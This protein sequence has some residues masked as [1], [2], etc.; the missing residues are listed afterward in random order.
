MQCTAE[1]A[2][3]GPTSIKSHI[4]TTKKPLGFLV[5]VALDQTWQSADKSRGESTQ[6]QNYFNGIEFRRNEFSRAGVFHRFISK[7]HTSIE[8]P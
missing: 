8:T 4:K 5:E 7:L 6:H 2:G 3:F 1:I